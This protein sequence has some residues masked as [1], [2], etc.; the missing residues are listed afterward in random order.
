MAVQLKYFD[1]HNLNPGVNIKIIG[2]ANCGKTYF[3]R[4]ILHILQAKNCNIMK[5][6][7]TQNTYIHPANPFTVFRVEETNFR[8][9]V[10]DKDNLIF[11][12]TTYIKKLVVANNTYKYFAEENF[13]AP[14]GFFLLHDGKILYR[15]Q[16]EYSSLEYY[17]DY[18]RN[19][20]CYNNIMKLINNIT[21]G[22]SMFHKTDTIFHHTL[23]QRL[24]EL[25]VIY[26]T[27]FSVK[28][29]GSDDMWLPTELNLEIINLLYLSY[30]K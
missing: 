23:Q 22:Y 10:N 8:N 14:Y 5:N 29:N 9:N 20:F 19:T 18:N 24:K 4:N 1:L 16:A 27:I 21:N 12:H 6:N 7:D 11:M 25:Y 17:L 3:Q 26:S 30:L 13:T 15:C 2:P 28:N